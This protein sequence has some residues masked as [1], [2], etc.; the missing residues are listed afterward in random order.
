TT[1]LIES[2]LNAA[3]H[4]T[5]ACGNIGM[6]FAEAVLRQGQFDFFAVE[7]SSFQLETIS[8]FRPEIAVWLNLTPDHLDRYPNV[9]EYRAAKLRIFENQ[10]RNHH[11][12]INYSDD[13]PEIAA[14]KMNF[15]AYTKEA[16]FTLP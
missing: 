8:T 6:P 12:V 11:A 5:V 10:K 13:L 16:D 14:R 3:G 1:Q 15:S 9:E 4:R 2:M 7:V